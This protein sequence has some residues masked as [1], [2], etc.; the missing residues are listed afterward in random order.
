MTR[1]TP[2]S[3]L[4]K[5]DYCAEAAVLDINGHQGCRQHLDD[6]VAEASKVMRAVREAF[7]RRYGPGR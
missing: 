6:A 2:K 1:A 5:C 3:V 4:G 7:D